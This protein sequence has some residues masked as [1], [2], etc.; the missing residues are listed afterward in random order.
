MLRRV[1]EWP[2]GG[3]RHRGL[4]RGSGAAGLPGGSP[5]ERGRA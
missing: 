1:P 3:A 2:A 5:A 4:A